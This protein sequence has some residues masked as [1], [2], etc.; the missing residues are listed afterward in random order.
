MDI[1][2]SKQSNETKFVALPHDFSNHCPNPSYTHNYHTHPLP[3]LNCTHTHILRT[4]AHQQPI[5]TANNSHISLSHTHA[6]AGENE[7]ELFQ[8]CN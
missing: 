5:V 3:V 6:V 4:H 1:V 7:D 2:E 8:L